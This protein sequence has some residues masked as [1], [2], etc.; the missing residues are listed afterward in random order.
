MEVT[1]TRSALLEL[2]EEKRL[3]T[4]GFKFLDE[5][6]LLLVAEIMRQLARHGQVQEEWRGLFA[7]ARLALAHAVER[8]GLLDLSLLPPVGEVKA[9][10]RQERDFFGVRLITVQRQEVET[11]SQPVA[12]PSPEGVACGRLFSQL[13]V[14]GV[15]LAA[16]SGNL[17]RL[18]NEYRRT[19]RRARALEDV[20]LPDLESNLAEM[21]G[22]LEEM[23]QE[24]A[25]RVRLKRNH[26]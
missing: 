4:E 23:D 14:I 8:H 22:R 20:I 16:L 13:A 21:T 15:E 18:M 10:S 1:A 3:F 24:E 12:L 7:K 26:A 9:I 19:E 11:A 17:Q 5:K 25:I 2:R 6:R